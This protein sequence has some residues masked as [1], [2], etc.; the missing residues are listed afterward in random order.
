MVWVACGMMA[1]CAWASASFE[2]LTD[3]RAGAQGW[4]GNRYVAALEETPEGITFRTMAP[5]PWIESPVLAALPTDSPVEV[6]FRMRST[7]DAH[8]QLFYGAEFSADRVASF[9]VRND[10][11]WHDYRITLPPL[12]PEP[13]LRIDPA[14]TAG[15]VTLAWIEVRPLPPAIETELAEAVPFTLPESRP[16][17]TAGALRVDIHPQALNAYTVSV[18]GVEMARSHRA[19][20]IGYLHEGEAG[21]LDFSEAEAVAWDA[22]DGTVS[23]YAEQEDRG[24]ARWRWTLAFSPDGEGAVRITSAVTVSEPRLAFHLPMVTLLPGFG[25]FGERKT[26]ALLPGVE[27]LEDEPS[28]SEADLRGEQAIRRMV[29][30]YRITFPLMTLVH[31]ERYIGLIWDRAEGAQ[32]VFDSPDT[33]LGSDAHLMGLWLPAVGEARA[34]N[35]LAVQWPVASEDGA[36]PAVTAT[37]IGGEAVSVAPAIAQ[38]VARRGLPELPVFEGGLDKAVTLLA[39]GW[40]D[41][42]AHHDGTWRH[43]VWHDYFPPVPAADAVAM[44]RWLAAHTDDDALRVRLEEAAARGHARLPENNPAG[45]GVGHVRRHT[46]ALIAAEREGVIDA[47]IRVRET[48]ARHLLGQFDEDGILPYTPV[49]GRL[50]YGETHFTNHANGLAAT[51]LREIL[52]TAVLTGEPEITQAALELLD[53]QTVLYANSVPRGA[54]TWEIALHTPDILASAGM[55]Q[56]YT[57][58]YLLTG[59]ADYLAEARYWAWTGLSFVY[60]DNPT[61]NP[62]GPYATIAVLG[63]TNWVSPNWIGL[64]VQWCGLVYRSA[65]EELAEVD[66]ENA[67]LWRRVAHGITLSGLQQTFPLDDEERQGLL[68]DYTHLDTQIGEGPAINPGTVQFH[69]PEVYGATPFFGRVRLDATGA[70]VTAPGGVTVERDEADTIAVTIAPWSDGHYCVVLT[71]LPGVWGLAD[72]DWSGVHGDGEAYVWSHPPQEGDRTRTIVTV[73][74]AGTVTLRAQIRQ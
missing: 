39:H 70:I 8:G 7:A 73:K 42:A 62:I 22:A 48:Q 29:E 1:V 5:D 37:I 36:F 33:L 64:P 66:P 57:L 27:Y 51:A 25:T 74:G 71:Q 72:F 56:C 21:Y 31:E 55:M 41:S 16:A 40:L 44:M 35:A 59:R 50:D 17:V 26:Q 60:L 53:Q 2:M 28:S 18:D 46:P 19:A 10:G 52:E 34:E 68:P 4:I 69:L 9:R 58:G 13:R 38:F 30:D 43:A 47:Y 11:G 15:E 49:P 61:P 54:Q 45:P 14:A 32:A 6:R 65:L 12:G 24:G 67:E 23:I 20:R 63:A 3:F